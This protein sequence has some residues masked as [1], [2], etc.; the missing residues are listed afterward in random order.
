MKKAILGRL[1][2]AILLPATRF[3]HDF[4][5]GWRDARYEPVHRQRPEYQTNRHSYWHLH[6]VPRR[7]GPGY[8]DLHQ[9][10][11]ADRFDRFDEPWSRPWSRF[12]K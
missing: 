7:H 4:F 8:E 12:E 6:R 9:W 2:A 5:P 1:A 3:A 11:A 10:H